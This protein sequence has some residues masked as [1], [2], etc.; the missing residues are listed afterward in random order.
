[1]DEARKSKFTSNVAPVG[2]NHEWILDVVAD[3]KAYAEQNNLGPM[4]ASAAQMLAV[5][6]R[7]IL[8]DGKTEGALVIPLHNA[9]SS[10]N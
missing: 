2:A 5:A 9:P 4:Q 6:R 10:L 3:L 1:M 7:D 8:G